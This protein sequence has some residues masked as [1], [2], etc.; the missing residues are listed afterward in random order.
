MTSTEK[1]D[2]H[3]LPKFYQKR[4]VLKGEYWVYDI[5]KQHLSRESPKYTATREH[6]NTLVDRDGNRD[7]TPEDELGKIESDAA[8]VSTKINDR[9][10][11]TPKHREHLALFIAM[12]RLRGPDFHDDFSEIANIT[13]KSRLEVIMADPDEA[14]RLWKQA[15]SKG[16]TSDTMTF[17]EAREIFLSDDFK[18]TA[19][20]N[21]VLEFM[22]KEATGLASVLLAMNW[23]I[24]CAPES[25]HFVTC[26]KPLV[27]TP[28]KG[29][30][31]YRGCGIGTPGAW[32]TFP[33]SLTRCLL[34]TGLGTH[35]DYH[36]VNSETVRCINLNT[37]HNA[38]GFIS[39]GSHT[40][41]HSLSE[42]WFR[43]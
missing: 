25:D 1:V 22:F 23:H 37:C 29:A 5:A 27:V 28:P 6:Y 31:P 7:Q 11:L 39:A 41:S 19:H 35:C 13:W 9:A 20:R 30:S 33:L 15:V 2:Q 18:V 34:I 4:F 21:A 32:K 3:F 17:A 10:T 14:E 24:L 40:N 12:Q 16:A 42:Q 26:D 36:S 38:S 8:R 43:A